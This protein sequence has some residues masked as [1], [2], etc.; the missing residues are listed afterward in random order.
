MKK[1]DR[2]TGGR[3]TEFPNDKIAEN[4]D[5]Q[6]IEEADRGNERER[7]VDLL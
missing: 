5:R 3:K 6:K 4:R 2:K 1:E 7:N